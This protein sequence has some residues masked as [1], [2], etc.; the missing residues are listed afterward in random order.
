MIH[1]ID[2][3]LLLMDSRPESVIASLAYVHPSSES[4]AEDIAEAHIRFENGGVGSLSAS[5]TA[6]RKIRTLSV[7]NLEMTAEV[8]LMRQD[9]TIYRH[10]L[11]TVIKE[12][13]PGYRQETIMEIPQLN[14]R[15]EPLVAQLTHFVDLVTGDVDPAIEAAGVLESHRVLAACQ[16]SVIEARS[17]ALN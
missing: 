5:R 12:D 15:T 6:Q 13:R 8:D 16:R 3:A 2:L 14:Y 9:I 7:A 4:D 11:S 17:V 1:D 10:V